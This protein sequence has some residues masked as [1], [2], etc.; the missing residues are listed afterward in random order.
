[1]GK[2]NDL[3]VIYKVCG[4]IGNQPLIAALSIQGRIAVSLPNFTVFLSE[5]TKKSSWKLLNTLKVLCQPKP[6]IFAK[7]KYF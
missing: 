6:G 4:K 3:L 2:L 5:W 1:M 7:D